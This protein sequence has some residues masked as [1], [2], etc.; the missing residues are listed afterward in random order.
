M[1]PWVGS[2]GPWGPSVGA[3]PLTGDQEEAPFLNLDQGAISCHQALSEDPVRRHI[4]VMLMYKNCTFFSSIQRL[5]TSLLSFS[6]MD[7]LFLRNDES[8]E[9]REGKILLGSLSQ[10]PTL[11]FSF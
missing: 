1:G 3:F 4:P 8:G 10:T 11:T 2:V 6:L 7:E 5:L 9:K